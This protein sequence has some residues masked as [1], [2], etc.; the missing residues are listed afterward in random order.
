MASPVDVNELFSKCMTESVTEK[1]TA[2]TVATY[3]T[4]PFAIH[5]DKFAPEAEKDE[6]TAFEELLFQRG[7]DHED[8]TVHDKFPNSV[9]MPF[10]R[11]EDGFKLIIDSMVSG[12]DIL[13]GAPIYYLPEGIFGVA[14]ILEKSNTE[15]SIFGNYHYT[16]KEVKLA[17]NIKENHI[18][19]GA[20]YNYL[21]GKIQGITPKTFAMINGD[22]EESLHEYSDYDQLLFDSIDG[23]RKIL[24]GG[25]IS[26][27]YGSCDYPWANYCN[28][29]AVE[30]NDISL[31]AGISLKTKNMLV[32]N[33]FNTVEDLARANIQDLTGI[34]GIGNKTAKKYVTA[35]KAIQ[36]KTHIITDKGMI[37]F[38]ERKVEIFLDLEGIDP[39][40]AA[41]GIPQI[42]YLIGILVRVDSKENYISFTAK[43]AKEDAEKEM[44]LEFLEFIKKQNDYVIYH[45][46]PYEKTHLTTMMKKYE[47]DE[48][49]KKTVLDYLI[50]VYK[51]AKNSV[52]FPTY[53]NGLKQIAP[54]LG[55]SWRHK[56]VSATESISM[57][58]DYVDN[59]EEGKV[60]FQ[61]IIDYNEDDCIATRVIKDWL[62]S[63]NASGS[64]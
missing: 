25:S 16:I 34:K 37:D 10:E 32:D 20:F 24:Q 9:T 29:K 56:D 18:L 43:E 61:K 53:G 4:S 60:K 38:P 30:T 46:A 27:T 2:R 51:V 59:S 54:Y 17:K 6:I 5:C 23:T 11:P 12:T 62:V 49:T 63:L 1:L 42:D 48:A 33:K 13:H 58:L 8:Q 64:K 26:P 14:D 3:I 41:D 35:A 55:F 31:T 28:K 47:I 57:Y 22:G 36:T 40:T 45:Y 21:L 44:L 39:T 50:D 19:Q 15:S 7:N 52:A